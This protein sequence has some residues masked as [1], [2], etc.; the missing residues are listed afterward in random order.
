MSNFA[1]LRLLKL[2][3]ATTAGSIPTQSPTS[4]YT[5]DTHTQKQHTHIHQ[6]TEAIR[7]P[8]L[9]EYRK[10]FLHTRHIKYRNL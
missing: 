2:R 5:N 3:T 8:N 7:T 4:N 6:Q 9:T 1:A 10:I